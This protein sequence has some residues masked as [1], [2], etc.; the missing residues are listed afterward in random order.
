MKPVVIFAL[1]AMVPAALNTSPAAA[2]GRLTMPLCTGDGLART[3]TVPV[4]QARL[5]GSE[6]PGCCQK[7]CHSGSRKRSRR[8]V[9]SAQ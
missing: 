7:G 4:G 1:V 6:P 9:D 2:N 3:I 8:A 5:P